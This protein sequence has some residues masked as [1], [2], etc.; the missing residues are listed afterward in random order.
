M[1]G[2]HLEDLGVIGRIILKIIFEKWVGGVM[3]WIDLAQNKDRWWVFVN[4][5]MNFRVL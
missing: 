2:D 4:A 1:E 5:I 3:E